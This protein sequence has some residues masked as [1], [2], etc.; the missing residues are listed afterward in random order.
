M[1]FS[2]ISG[3]RMIKILMPNSD[4]SVSVYSSA[5]ANGTFV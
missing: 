5:I 2:R 4:N 3:A 1:T